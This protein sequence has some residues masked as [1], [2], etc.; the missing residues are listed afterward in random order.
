MSQIVRPATAF[1]LD[2]LRQKQ[3]AQKLRRHLAFVGQLP[4]LVPG[5]EPVQVAHIRYADDHV[6]K[7]SAGMGMKPSDWWVVPLAADQHRRQHE[8]N[9][10]A[11]WGEAGINPLLIAALLFVHGQTE[12]VSAATIVIRNARRITEGWF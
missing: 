1:A 7:R 5:Y 11:F 10:R 12:D 8:M 4:S 3:P 6:G 9:E 2:G